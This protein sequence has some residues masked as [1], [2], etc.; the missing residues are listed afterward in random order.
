LL[1]VV[2][3]FTFLPFFFGIVDVPPLGINDKTV[4]VEEY[5]G[6]G[7]DTATKN[8]AAKIRRVSK[9]QE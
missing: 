6:A 8:V 5:L 9:E 7:I 4:V 1:D 2:E 3:T